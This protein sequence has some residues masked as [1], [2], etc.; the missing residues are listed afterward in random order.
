MTVKRVEMLFFPQLIRH[1]THTWM[2]SHKGKAR[3]QKRLFV[4]L[5]YTAIII[6]F[7]TY[8]ALNA[9]LH[10][11][12]FTWF[13]LFI[14]PWLAFAFGIG[15]IQL[16]KRQETVGWWLALPYPRLAL[17][18]SKFWS[19][20]LRSLEVTAILIGGIV[21]LD[22]YSL[23]ISS[24]LSF[25]VLADI[26]V[27]GMRPT[28]LVLLTLPAMISIGLFLGALSLTRWRTAR[29]FAIL[30]WILAGWLL[31]SSGLGDLIWHE[32][33]AV[34]LAVSVLTSLSTTVAALGITAWIL[35]KRIDL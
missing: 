14:M 9:H 5:V 11:K 34:F 23:W 16:E 20:L 1:E 31:S 13:I 12:D 26:V 3:K 35:T 19:L 10:S 17:I 25:R 22:V 27:L 24:G 28:L 33:L 18:S 29:R 21:L 7:T 2:P 6:T 15:S 30:F 4:F 32:T 8:F